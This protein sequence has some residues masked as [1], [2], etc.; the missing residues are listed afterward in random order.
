MA[1]YSTFADTNPGRSY[2]SFFYTDNG[3]FYTISAINISVTNCRGR[4]LYDA[5]E[6]LEQ[7]VFSFNNV[8][9]IATVLTKEQ[10]INYFHYTVEGLN[11]PTTISTDG[12]CNETY[13]RPGVDP[14]GF[15]NSDYNVLFANATD[16]RTSGYIYDVDRIGDQAIPTNYQ[17]II[18]GSAKLATVPDSNYTS[19][20]L[21]QSRYNGAKTS[22]AEYGISPA[23]SVKLFSGEVFDLEKSD[24][25]ICSKSYSDRNIED[26]LFAPN[27]STAASQRASYPEV[28]TTRT[29]ITKIYATNSLGA[30]DTTVDF[31]GYYLDEVEVGD[32][33][34]I[35][36]ATYTTYELM[37]VES[38]SLTEQVLGSPGTAASSSFG[39]TR[40]YYADYLDDQANGLNYTEGVTRVSL[41]IVKGDEIFNGN[42][43]QAFRISDR[44]IW[45]EEN[46]TVIVIDERGQAIGVADSC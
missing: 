43:D 8:E 17:N 44:K 27:I 46:E 29:A 22:T 3:S 33:I 39:V 10:K 6:K 9:Y 4:N 34:R 13:L 1:S 19:I 15:V 21:K 14:D 25:L 37:K 12:V 26:V 35:N 2:I 7:I 41:E 42:S 36:T 20:G 32:I 30:N 18:S 38:V 5:L 23:L 16:N 11:V 28:R 31:Y 24:G 40:R 45:I